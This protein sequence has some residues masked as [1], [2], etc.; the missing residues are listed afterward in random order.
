MI[1]ILIEVYFGLGLFINSMLFVPQ[2]IRI[3]KTKQAHDASLITF[4]GFNLI[5]IA[6]VLHGIIKHDVILAVGY[7]MSV[8]TNSCVTIAIIW[9]RYVKP[10]KQKLAQNTN[11]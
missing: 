4:A 2:I 11:L 10:Y 6:C 9:F 3:L 5:N 8:I 1:D 7:G